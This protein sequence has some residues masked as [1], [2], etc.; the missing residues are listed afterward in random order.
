M[1]CPKCNGEMEEG[2]IV[3]KAHLGVGTKPMWATNIKF[4]GGPQNKHNVVSY[5]CK[6]CGYLESYA[7][8][9][10]KGN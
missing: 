10:K 6:S 4:F 7:K 5:R 9:T 8:S 1:K 3:D 2:F